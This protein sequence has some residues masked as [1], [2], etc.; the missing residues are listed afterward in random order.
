MLNDQDRQPGGKWPYFAPDEIEAA[1]RVLRTGKVNFWTG[2]E[3]RKF[4]EE[5][6]QYFGRRHAIALSNGTIALELALRALGIGPGDEVIVPC[7]TFIASASAVVRCG[8][9]PVL[10][11]V[12]A[13]SQNITV[14]TIT[15]VIGPATKAIIVVHLAGWP[16]EMNEIMDLARANN[17]KVVEDCAQ[18]HGAKLRGRLAGEF[19]DVAA[20]SFCQDKIMTTG[21]EGGMVV[22]DDSDLWQKMWS[23][24]DHG[25]SPSVL[26]LHSDGSRFR[27]LHEC[28]GTNGRMTEMQA[29]IGRIQLGKLCGWVEQ[30][31]RNASVLSETFFTRTGLRVTLPPAHVIHS[32]YKY[33]TFVRPEELRPGW[34]RDRILTEVRQRG[35][36]C[37]TGGCPELYL[38]KAFIDKGYCPEE[39]MPVAKMLGETSLMFL[40]HPTLEEQEMRRIG[41]VVS[42][43]FDQ[44]TGKVA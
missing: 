9:R 27:L 23:D 21:G 20:F 35:I 38:E 32:Y 30:R 14:G 41:D 42:E 18:A 22:T 25:K 4:E 5:F 44:A 39:R 17:L 33:Y 2:G 11:D 40:V 36:V 28:F 31:R 19:G 16:C 15:P 29:A 24:K 26:D 6:A 34:D 10:A 3:C 13:E 7:R 12:D 43:V 37:M 1:V 8:A